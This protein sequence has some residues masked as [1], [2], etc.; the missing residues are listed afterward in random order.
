M[1]RFA[2]LLMGLV[3]AF[4]LC[5]CACD[6][7]DPATTPTVTDNPTT[8]STTQTTTESAT[9]DNMPTDTVEIPVPDTNIPD[10]SV[11]EGMNGGDSTGAESMVQPQSYILM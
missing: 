5:A 4:G 9:E 7:M 10:S 11:N 2:F 8:Q 6:N 1:K 3:L